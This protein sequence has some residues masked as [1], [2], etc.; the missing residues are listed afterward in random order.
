MII[1]CLSITL[2]VKRESDKILFLFAQ[3]GIFMPKHTPLMSRHTF[4]KLEALTQIYAQRKTNIFI[5]EQVKEIIKYI[6]VDY[7]LFNKTTL[8]LSVPTFNP[9]KKERKK[10]E[11]E[12]YL[13]D[14]NVVDC[15]KNEVLVFIRENFIERVGD[16]RSIIQAIHNS[17]FHVSYEN[18][19]KLIQFMGK[20]HSYDFVENATTQ[21][22]K[23]GILD[24][25][26][27][28][29]EGKT[30]QTQAKKWYNNILKHL[31][32]ECIHLMELTDTQRKENLT[33]GIANRKKNNDK[34]KRFNDPNINF[35]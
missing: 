15:S 29:L 6:V 23:Q 1:F 32:Y 16:N 24:F 14:K 34:K 26:T 18:K 11:P 10:F 30:K 17:S 9:I 7:I 13:K 27:E 33:Q 3:K 8:E 31:K 28:L 20:H 4:L 25:M 19:Q 35:F 12:P 2:Y 22:G 5:D 21:E